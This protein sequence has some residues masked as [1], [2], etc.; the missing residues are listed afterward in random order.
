MP[1]HHTFMKDIDEFARAIKIDAGAL[2]RSN[3]RETSCRIIDNLI[4]EMLQHSL[5][6][7]NTL[8]SVKRRRKPE[9]SQTS[10]Q[11][12]EAE[13]Q[14]Y[15]NNPAIGERNIG[16]MVALYLPESWEDKQSGKTLDSDQIILQ[17][18]VEYPANLFGGNHDYG[19]APKNI[20]VIP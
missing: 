9:Q 8:L 3:A 13:R 4:D 2:A 7:A 10:Q 20:C 14:E 17:L 19:R 16:M 1:I 6:L 15:V 12:S 11:E 18:Q 5:D